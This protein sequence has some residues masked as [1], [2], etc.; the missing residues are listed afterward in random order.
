[1]L[2]ATL[3]IVTA[4]LEIGTGL[5]LLFV[6]AVAFALLLGVSEAAPEALLVARVAGAALVALGVASGAARNSEPSAVQRGLLLGILIYDVAAAA[7]LAYAG[8]GLGMVGIV[9][10]PA[11][12]IHTALAVGFMVI[13]RVKPPASK[14][15][16]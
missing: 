10:W 14:S 12:V 5:V 15:I 9:L 1:M 6:P 8:L 16:K 2:R 7:L 11:V 13:L 4:V 3:L